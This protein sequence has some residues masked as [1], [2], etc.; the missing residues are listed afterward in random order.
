MKNKVYLVGAGP[1]KSDLITVRGLNILK[2]ADVIIH[3]YLVDKG[4]FSEAKK[5]A[6]LICCNGPSKNRIN[7][8]SDLLIRKVNEG[9]KVVR[10]KNGDVSVFGRYS[11][12]LGALVKEKIDFEVVPGVTAASAASSLSGIPLTD[13]DIASSCVFVTGQEDPTKKK[14]LLDWNSLAK[15]GTLV[16]YMAVNNL[17]NIIKQLIK[18]GK[19]KN[20][21]VAIV[22]DAGLPT[23]KVLTGIL[24]S[25]IAKAKSHRISPPAIVIIGEV[26]RLEKKF[27]WLKKDR[28]VLFTGLSQERFFTK[29]IYFHLPLIRIEPIKD[30]KEFDSYLKNVKDF[31]WIIFA[32][33]YGVYY[34]FERLRKL[35]LDSRILNG[36]KIAAVGSSTSNRLLEFRIIADLVPKE[37]S[38]KGLIEEFRRTNLSGKKVFLPRSDIAD[39]GLSKAFERLGARVTT[40]FAY[41]NV[42]PNDLPDLDLNFFSEIM[43]TSPSTVRN[44][45][46]R[47]KKVP[48]KIKISCIGD[49]TRREAKRCR[50][51]A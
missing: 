1:G 26:A 19:D 13:R 12:E 33:R 22:Q 49:V 48:K 47:Y 36:I 31:D 46:E 35:G 20:T 51:L 2:E 43:F 41:R 14:S 16:L 24:N 28:R 11:Q 5:D 6:E 8:I 44:F 4:I 10:L 39:K 17:E 15:S 50:L 23:Q 32:S 7:R 45:R 25:I 9:K 34:F 21:A 42:I 38:S 18:A 40:S 30:Y 27:N 29:G 37:E 3:D